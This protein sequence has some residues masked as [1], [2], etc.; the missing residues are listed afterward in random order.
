MFKFIVQTL[1]SGYLRYLV[2]SSIWWADLHKKM[3]PICF[4]KSFYSN[5]IL[6]EPNK[7]KSVQ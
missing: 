2:Q 7:S 4:F 1:L 3:N 6:A 5:I